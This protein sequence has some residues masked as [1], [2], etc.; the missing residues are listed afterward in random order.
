MVDTMRDQ[1]N[2]KGNGLGLVICEQ[3]VKQ[4]D[5]SISYESEYNKGS[6]FFFNLMADKVDESQIPPVI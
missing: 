6:N 5:G 3:I 4:F 1:V 2:L